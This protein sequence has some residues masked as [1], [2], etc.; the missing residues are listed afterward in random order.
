MIDNEGQGTAR[1]NQ[2][3]MGSQTTSETNSERSEEKGPTE[4]L[5]E[6]DK[7]QAQQL[8]P[9]AGVPGVQKSES[10]EVKEETNPNTE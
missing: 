2:Q 10:Q 8:V 3:S 1:D 4:K 9:G 5:R 6:Q 7:P